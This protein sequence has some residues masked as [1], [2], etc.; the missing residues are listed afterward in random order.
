MTFREKAAL[1]RKYGFGTTYGKRGAGGHPAQ[2]KAAITRVWSRVGRYIDNPRF[3][4][5]HAKRSIRDSHAT[6]STKTPGGW[7][8]Q[9]PQ[10]VSKN[11]VKIRIKGKSVVK[12]YYDPSKGIDRIDTI[13]PLLSERM[14]TDPKEYVESELK[15]HKGAKY[16]VIVVKGF[17]GLNYMTRSVAAD[18][19]K[20]FSYELVEEQRKMTYEEFEDTFQL[21]IITSKDERRS[22]GPK[23]K[24]PKRKKRRKTK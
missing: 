21:K 9:I 17:E 8:E 6:R 14:A 7:F 4:H 5:V 2:K 20:E 23:A 10:G 13:V 11:R 22:Y 19:I 12:S 15:K 3:V 18:Y 24:K 16:S 1:L